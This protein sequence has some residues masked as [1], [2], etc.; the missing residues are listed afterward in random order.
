MTKD[1]HSIDIDRILDEVV[2][3]HPEYT[4]EMLDEVV[5]LS[6][7]GILARLFLNQKIDE[8]R[9]KDLK[10]VWELVMQNL[11]VLETL[12]L[13]RGRI[14]NQLLETAEE[15]AQAGRIPVVIILIATVIEHRLNIF[16]RD[17]LEDYSGLSSDEATE[18]IRSNISAKLS[19]LYHLT[20]HDHFSSELITQVK[21]IF[22]LR[23]AFV[24]YKSAMVTIDETAKTAELI[25]RVKD[26]GFE[27]ILD[28]PNKIDKE[29]AEKVPKLV[30]A[31]Q[32]AYK[33]AEAMV[34][35]SP[36]GKTRGKA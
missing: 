14:D 23:N 33:L 9:T 28:L 4:H 8:T 13:I 21:Q 20:T 7:A 17:I 11:D 6:V 36:K 35:R 24:H 25:K 32:K 10:Y 5:E 3:A 26:I 30:P 12:P 22:D 27:N 34:N 18:A 29:L 31:Y 15:A 19:W 1:L 2:T 16:Y